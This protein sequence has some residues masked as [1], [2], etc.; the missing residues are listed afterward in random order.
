MVDLVVLYTRCGNEWL[1]HM[2][3]LDISQKLMVYSESICKVYPF[4]FNFLFHL[5]RWLLVAVAVEGFI[6]VKY[7]EHLETLCNLERARAVILLLTVLL[8]CVNLHFFWSYELVPYEDFNIQVFFCTFSKYGHQR[9]EEFQ[10]IIWPMLDITVSDIL[11]YTIVIVC[12]VIM[13]V[14]IC[15]GR[16]K[17]GKSFQDWQ[18]KYTLDSAAITQSKVTL[19]MVAYF[20]VFLTLPKFG[21]EIFKY[22][23]DSHQMLEY[24]LKLDAQ[25]TLASAV[26][27]TLEYFSLSCKL[28]VYCLSSRRFRLEVLGLFQWIPACKRLKFRLQKSTSATRPLISDC[29][30]TLNSNSEPMP[31]E[32]S[33]ARSEYPSIITTV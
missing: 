10:N 33:P 26:F 24:T 29:S 31:A 22:L 16:H 18:A 15:R 4:V 1:I 12:C 25:M 6:S 9:S 30:A 19:L 21:F 13:T 5:S 20:F 27:T 11:P 32:L 28:F 3:N 17:G 8:I 7:P 23:K 2:A 14:Q